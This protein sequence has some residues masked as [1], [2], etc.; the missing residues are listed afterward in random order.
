MKLTEREKEI[1]EE[2][3]KRG[4][5]GYTN[6]WRCPLVID[7]LD[8]ICYANVDGRTRIAK[9]QKRYKEEKE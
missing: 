7:Q 5:D 1:C 2:Y 4:A 6:C 8:C 3:G 9:K